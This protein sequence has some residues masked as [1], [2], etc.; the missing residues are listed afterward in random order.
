MTDQQ[1][2]LTLYPTLS[3]DSQLR[4]LL[5]ATSDW[6]ED[7]PEKK[8]RQQVLNA[9]DELPI[10]KVADV[11]QKPVHA[12]PKE[13][14]HAASGLAVFGDEVIFH[15]LSRILLGLLAQH[16][17][18][19]GQGYDWMRYMSS[20]LSNS[21]AHSLIKLCHHLDREEQQTGA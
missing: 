9:I 4:L 20:S 21:S 10:E 11:A 1:S 14:R 13:I 17:H 8:L 18:A 15:R 12:D 6:M 16:K 3:Q 5:A 19:V 2:L 7:V